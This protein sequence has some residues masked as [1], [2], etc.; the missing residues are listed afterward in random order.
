MAIVNSIALWLVMASISLI[1]I[2]AF[3]ITDMEELGNEKE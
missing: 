1:V 3:L 2:I